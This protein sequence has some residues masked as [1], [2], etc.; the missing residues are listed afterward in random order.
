MPRKKDQDYWDRHATFSLELDLTWRLA[1]KTLPGGK[2]FDH[3]P[4]PEKLQIPL[5]QVKVRAAYKS[6]AF[7]RA[8]P[9]NYLGGVLPEIGRILTIEGFAI[10]AG[11]HPNVRIES[12]ANKLQIALEF[13]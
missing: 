4:L 1:V 6:L 5:L 2:V 12:V 10:L 8:N 7:I 3:K 9:V 13:R 11:K